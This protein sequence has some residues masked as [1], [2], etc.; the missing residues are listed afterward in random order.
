[1][2]ECS[3]SSS[4][5]SGGF[6]MSCGEVTCHPAKNDMRE[7]EEKASLVLRRFI[8]KCSLALA[9]CLEMQCNNCDSSK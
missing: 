5:A 2:I 6:F 1:M 4:A 9:T 7:Y 8:S 3:D